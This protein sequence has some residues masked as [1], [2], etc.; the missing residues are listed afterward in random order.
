MERLLPAVKKPEELERVLVELR[1][2]LQKTSVISG[3][4]LTIDG[5][6]GT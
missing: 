1:E 6:H 5:A 3:K 4:L 2:V